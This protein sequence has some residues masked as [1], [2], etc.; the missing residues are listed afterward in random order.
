MEKFTQQERN[1]LY[2]L[3]DEARAELKGNPYYNED[4]APTRISERT[5]NTYNVTALWISICI[6]I[7][8]FA[9]AAGL[10]V[11]GLSPWLAVFNITLGN[12]LVLIPMQLNS[13]AGTQYGIP[14]PIFSRMTFGMRGAH[15]PSLARGLAACGW[16]AF[17]CWLGAWALVEIF[18]VFVPGVR[19]SMLQARIVGFFVFLSLCMWATIY[20]AGALKKLKAFAGPI[21]AI[22][23][24]GAFAWSLH[25]ALTAGYTF[26]DVIQA[27]SDPARIAANGGLL[28]IFAGGLT[29]NIGFWGT[30]AINIPDFS[31]YANSLKAQ[32]RGQLYAVPASMFACAFIGAFMAQSTRLVYGT[33]I[34]NPMLILS[35][36]ENPVLVIIVAAAAA[37]ATLT[38]NIAANIVAPANG[39]TNLIPK[40][41]SYKM[42]VVITCLLAIAF[43]PWWLFTY[44]ERLFNLFIGTYG[45]ILA[46]LAAIFVA[47]FYR[48]KQC[49]LNVVDLFK[50]EQGRYWYSN[51]FNNKAIIAWVAGFI[52]PTI[53]R[54]MAITAGG[55]IGSAHLIDNFFFRWVTANAYIFGFVVAY[56]VYT[57]IMDKGHVSFV[58]EEENKAITAKE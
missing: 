10:V 45:G 47:D 51:G 13:R 33:A 38:T 44:A 22:L 52:F 26:G 43:Q 35:R 50:G 18:A 49:R 23:I 1:G 14:F 8:S 15:I 21:L 28:L 30:M 48:I 27:S 58:S 54:V 16:N 11:L 7:P 12:L 24:V 36:L 6:C 17:Q 31:R 42:G 46:P 56:I 55:G 53:G 5:W 9:M 2:E 25:L 39:L 20:G 3:T 19:E 32:F 4:L 40:K 29:A 57:L 37:F 41:I 34:F